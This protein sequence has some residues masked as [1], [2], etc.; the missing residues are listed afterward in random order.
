MGDGVPLLLLNALLPLDEEEEEEEDGAG[1]DI[2][3]AITSC[4]TA[5]KATAT[6]S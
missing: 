3:R 6:I 1:C 2:G 4:E 5:R